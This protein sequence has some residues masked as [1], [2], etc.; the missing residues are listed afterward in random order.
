MKS[1]ANVKLAF[2]LLFCS[3]SALAG[4]G[5]SL[6]EIV[7]FN[8]DI[9]PIL[10]DNCYACHGT[11]KNKRKA[12]LRLDTRE[13]LF[14]PTK[15]AY[16]VVPGKLRLSELYQR[17]TSQDANEMM[18]HGGKRLS[19]Q[20]ITLIKRWIEQGAKWEDIWSFSTLTRPPVPPVKNVAWVKN[21]VDNFILW[22]LQKEKLAP[23]PEADRRTLIRRLSFDLTGLPP[24]PEETQAFIEDKD[25]QAYEKLV[26][27]LMASHHYG[28]RQAVYWLD[29]V[30]YA[31]TEGYHADNYQSVYPYR[32]YV[33][34][35]FNKNMRFDQFTIEQLAG[36]LLTN[37]TMSQKIASTYNRL[38]RTTEEGGAQPKEYLAKYAADRVR[39]TSMTWLGATLGCA[40]CHDHKFDP[41]KTR[42]FYNFEAF[43]ADI[44]EEGVGA[45]Q[46]SPAPSE[47]Q[48]AEMKKLEED[49]ARLQKVLDTS[50]PELATAQSNWEKTFAGQTSFNL[51]E[52]QTIGPFTAT[53]Y[54]AA[55]KET[56]E[57][58]KEIDLAKTY[59]RKD[60][61]A[62]LAPQTEGDTNFLAP[63]EVEMRWLARPGWSDG[64][65]HNG[66][67]TGPAA[68]YLY[69]TIEV[70]VAG[71]MHLSLGSGDG[72][73][74]WMDKTEVLNK[75]EK[76]ATA[77]D[78]DKI[79]V[80]L[81]AGEN[82]LLMK[83]VDEGDN[84]G[85]YFKAGEYD[86]ENMPA[87]LKIRAQD[88]T[89]QQKIELA[90]YY[91]TIAPAL[92][93][94]RTELATAKQ[95]YDG[96]VKDSPTT[97][98]TMAVAPRV[99]RVLPRGNWMSEAGD[100]VSPAVPSFLPH[101]DLGEGR[102]TRLD[103]ARWLI[104]RDNP[105]TARVFVNRLWKMFYGMGIS[106][107]LDD[108]GMRSEWPV[109]PELLDWLATEFRDS[110]WDMKHMVKLMVMS[111]TYRQSSV[112]DKKLQERDP[113][114]RLLAR[115]SSFRLD[116]EM[117]RDNALAIS[118]LLVD[119]VGGP[120][121]KVY[122]PAGY[123]DMMNFP[124]RTYQSDHGESQ[125]RRGLY[126]FWCR[127]FLQPSVQAFDAPSREECTVERVYSN[128]PLQALA[129]LNDPT[130]V[131]AARVLAEQVVRKA[132]T[133]VEDRINWTFMRALDRKPNP[134][135]F[136]VLNGFAHK[137][138]NRY[139]TN[140]ADAE[141][142]IGAGEWPVPKDLKAPELAAWTSI[143]RVVLNLHET[144]TRY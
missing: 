71:T 127:T 7:Q 36:D 39:T 109:H 43:F 83:I 53:N 2:A 119:K 26:D 133:N 72:I 17:I 114:N 143:S 115:Q 124:K 19:S 4:R 13:G 62:W 3:F 11:D 100:I 55:Y 45:P 33:I 113:F 140:P 46:G 65:V 106:K 98:S 134:E 107:T 96:L 102:A 91:R 15:D 105:L 9:R 141:K 27:R 59:H 23:S 136:Q 5:S 123:W 21:P 10:A 29:E 95:K 129:L 16:P 87:E 137:Q 108:S 22:R 94:T 142:L 73:K 126:T 85:F 44:K 61:F 1:S 88:R 63:P 14:S 131:E 67:Q 139:A 121:V 69:R 80:H 111:D 125:Y 60:E 20:Q 79:T 112:A 25:P 77:P 28:E 12:E 132:G 48:A 38:N 70:K 40:E 130:Y 34:D 75:P 81:H 97:L 68:T 117:V 47:Q 78:Q 41:Y 64:V 66:F 50:T 135:E 6:P 32:D 103:L 76:R 56:F 138:I 58:E 90:K 31:D 42:D 110:G 35:A 8:R 30:R 24:T 86:P 82:K 101:A 51:G 89:E 116:A 128:T 18:P 122:Q 57:P 99:M 120:S 93:A 84:S 74:V 118:G 54:D 144:I 104:A 52:W 49:K 92:E 37:A